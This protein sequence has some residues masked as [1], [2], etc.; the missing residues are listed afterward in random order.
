MSQS[1]DSS[2]RLIVF[3]LLYESNAH[4]SREWF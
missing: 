4:Q 1:A 2:F 3:S